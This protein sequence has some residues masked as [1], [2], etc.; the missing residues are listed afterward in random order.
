[1]SVGA[2]GWSSG[3][4]RWRLIL[5]ITVSAGRPLLVRKLGSK[6]T[7]TMSFKVA[8]LRSYGHLV[9][10]L[11]SQFC[12]SALLRPSC[13]SGIIQESLILQP[14][15]L[16]TKNQD[17]LWFQ[18]ICCAMI[19]R[20]KMVTFIYICYICYI[21]YVHRYQCD[22]WWSIHRTLSAASGR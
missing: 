13:L 6:I 4:S 9:A 21:R 22:C 15:P 10:P 17:L 19:L 11:S 18:L 20:P 5:F 8:S 3:A 12:A 1:M 2:S 7:S 14:S 16:F